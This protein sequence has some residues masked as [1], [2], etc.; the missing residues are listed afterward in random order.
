MGSN[1]KLWVCMYQVDF[2]GCVWFARKLQ[3]MQQKFKKKLQLSYKIQHAKKFEVC[4]LQSTKF[5][6]TKMLVAA[7]L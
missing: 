2:N 6:E 4:F 1:S 3:E 7:K 5:I